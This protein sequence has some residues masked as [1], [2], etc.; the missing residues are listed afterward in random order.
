MDARWNPAGY[1]RNVDGDEMV[2]LP[3]GRRANALRAKGTARG[4]SLPC[5]TSAATGGASTDERWSIKRYAFPALCGAVV[6]FGGAPASAQDLHPGIIGEDD[7]RA[8]RCAGPTV[9]RHRPSQCW[10]LQNCQSLY[11]DVGSLGRCVDS[12]PLRR[13]KEPWRKAPFPLHNIHFLAGVHG[14]EN[15][16]HAAA[17]CL[18]FPKGYEFVAPEKI[19]PTMPAQKVPL[20]AFATDVVAI[21]LKEKIAVDPVPLAENIMLQPGLGLVHA[22]Y[23]ADRRFALT[24]HFDCHLLRSDLEGPLWFNDCDTHPASSGGAL[25]TRMDGVLRLAAIM[26][27]TA[28]RISN[29]ALPISEWKELARNSGCP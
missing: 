27:G 2:L 14:S 1:M 29:V 24:A 9:G 22:A 23:P 25:F 12:S 6:I 3:N 28:D 26:L 18:H 4:K 17:K 5:R 15:K 13:I 16:G 10:R 11:R 19:L 8:C 21:V 7:R 20:R